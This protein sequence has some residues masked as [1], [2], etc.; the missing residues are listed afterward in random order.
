MAHSPLLSRKRLYAWH[1]WLGLHFGVLLY[2]IC[3]SGTV[4]VFTPEI[5]VWLD[6][7]RQVAVPPRPPPMPQTWPTCTRSRVRGT[8]C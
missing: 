7:V 5:D 8:R 2:A 4:A 1:G 6:P 3:L